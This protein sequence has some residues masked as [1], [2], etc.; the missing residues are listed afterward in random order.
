[1]YVNGM[2]QSTA[3]I[4]ADNNVMCY[5]EDRQNE[6]KTIFLGIQENKQ[7]LI[8]PHKLNMYPCRHKTLEEKRRQ[9]PN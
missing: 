9:V 4:T 8:L 5:P 2:E 7:Q 1:M 6:Q 3:G